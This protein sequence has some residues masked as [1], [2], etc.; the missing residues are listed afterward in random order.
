MRARVLVL[1]VFS[2]MLPAAALAGNTPLFG[3]PGGEAVN[4]SCRDGDY[5]VGLMGRV[6]DWMDQVRAIC[7]PW[8][9]D[10]RKFG[11]T[12]PGIPFGTS[13]GGSMFERTCPRGYAIAGLRGW[14]IVGDEH[15]AKFI[16]NLTASCVAV[17]PP[18]D[19]QEFTVGALAYG[20]KHG[21]Y[22]PNYGGGQ[23]CPAGELAVGLHGRAGL[24]VDALGLVCAPAPR[25]RT[26]GAI[27][28]VEA[29]QPLRPGS[30]VGAALEA[31]PVQSTTVAR[32]G[33]QIL[34]PGAGSRHPNLTPI[35]IRVAPPRGL[36]VETY[37]LELERKGAGGAW[38][39]VTTIPAVSARQAEGPLGYAGWG[40]PQPGRP[41]YVLST[42]G[43]WRVRARAVLP[44]RSDPG[45]WVEYIVTGGAPGPAIA[46]DAQMARPKALGK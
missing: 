23:A 28:G 22:T 37:L 12:V 5:L 32:V 25:P 36:K 2:A 14:Y 20:Q 10:Q 29:R 33:P 11:V 1:L 6:G 42:P 9:A 30:G 17:E 35:K 31:R 34:E 41:A 26:A 13:R 27:A 18:W 38:E 40:A 3:G 7:A 4:F 44:T 24:F 43:A 45:A 8:W 16:A 21:G 19:R 46:P 15:Q 39:A